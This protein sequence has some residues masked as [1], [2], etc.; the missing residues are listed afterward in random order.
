MFD[1][2]FSR[3]PAGPL[4]LAA[5]PPPQGVK[6]WLAQPAAYIPLGA[7]V[8]LLLLLA[9]LRWPEFR[10]WLRGRHRQTLRPV[11]FD[12]VLL[13][14][15]AIVIDLRP[16]AAFNGP[17][18]HVRGARNIPFDQLAKAVPALEGDPRGLVVLVDDTDKL[19]HHAAP[20]L[21]AAGFQWVRV[22]RG[23]M[24]AW[25]RSNLPVAVTGHHR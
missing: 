21:E 5:Q 7:G 15:K 25:R 18:G 23:G 12:P 2:L 22:L 17:R 19:S 8:F 4:L 11:E 10:S 13:G 3:G 9:V 20:I 6:G 24:R 14:A 1:H 16:P